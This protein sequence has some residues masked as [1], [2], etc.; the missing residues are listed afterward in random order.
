MYIDESCCISFPTYLFFFLLRAAGSSSSL[1]SRGILE[2]VKK[3]M[4]SLQSHMDDR[5]TEQSLR[6]C[7][8]LRC[9][10]MEQNSLSPLISP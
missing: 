8:T 6:H 4:Y 2:R 3:H 10:E 1:Y 9:S 5:W 7:R